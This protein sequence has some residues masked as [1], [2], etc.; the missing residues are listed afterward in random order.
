MEVKAVWYKLDDESPDRMKVQDGA[1]VVD[2]RDAIK[3]K[4]PELKDVAAARLKVFAAGAD[5]ASDEPF[6][7]NAAIPIDSSFEAPLIMT[8]SPQQQLQPEKSQW[9]TSQADFRILLENAGVVV[10]EEVMRVLLKH[11][12]SSAVFVD[13]A[14]QAKDLYYEVAMFPRSATQIT[15]RE[16]NISVA[17]LFPGSD[18]SKAILLHAFE[19]GE[20]RILKISSESSL[21]HELHVWN[22]LTGAAESEKHNAHLVPLDKLRFQAR[23]PPPFTLETPLVDLLYKLVFVADC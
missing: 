14:E 1:Q 17:E 10:S 19:N 20:P 5:T 7:A 18:P 15:L 11:Y 23:L 13:N 12:A 3:A 16:Q 8:A 6:K 22:D 4:W 21:Q 9:R 2:L